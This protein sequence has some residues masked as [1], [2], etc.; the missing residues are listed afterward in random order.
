MERIVRIAID[1]PGGAG[2]STV[3]KA[4]AARLRIQYIDTGAMYR[5]VGLKML[6][7]GLAMEE[8]PALAAMLSETEVS[9][10]DGEVLLDGQ[11]V[12]RD[13]RT[14]EVSMAASACSALP[15]VR[16]KLVEL[17]REMGKIR[18]VIMDGRDIGT[19][20]MPDAEFK[21]FLTAADTERARRR[22]AELLEKGLPADYDTVL[23]ELRE[24]DYQDTHR[25]IDPLRRA[26]DAEEIDSTYMT[27]DAV[28]ERICDR[29]QSAGGTGC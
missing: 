13:I 21:F 14:P 24:R 22:T 26:A 7:L 25:S 4:V 8:G 10:A 28:I 29:V 15:A 11:R 23:A 20:V 12:T 27:A 6:R 2:K 9:L 3:A 17:Q 19:N 1:G 18:S 5:A 16:R